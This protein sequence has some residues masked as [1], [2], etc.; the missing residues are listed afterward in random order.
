MKAA[1]TASERGHDV[2]LLEKDSK[3]GGQLKYISKE[4]FKED[5]KNSII[6]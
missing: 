5:V 1:I 3:L 4:F 6:I 2:T